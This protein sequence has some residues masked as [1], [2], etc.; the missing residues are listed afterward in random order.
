MERK[1]SKN[2]ASAQGSDPG[3]LWFPFLISEELVEH[4]V[5]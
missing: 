1:K 2:A 3:G 5:G 4:K